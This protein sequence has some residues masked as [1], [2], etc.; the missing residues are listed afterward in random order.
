MKA[1]I[2][3]NKIIAGDELVFD[4]FMRFNYNHLFYYA[5]ALTHNR[6]VAEEIVSDAYFKMWKNR[7]ELAKISNINSWLTTIIYRDSISW[8]RKEQSNKSVSLNDIDDFKI[9]PFLSPD[10]QMISKEEIGNINK[11]IASLSS[12]NRHIFI[13]AKIE[14]L[15]YEDIAIMLNISL[16]T[17]YNN[18]SIA[19]DAI[20][21]CLD[22]KSD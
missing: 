20:S 8:L 17:I 11:A 21:R 16:K 15:P 4:Q 14:G 3:I 19:L 10:N 9:A 1:K 13:L 18:V 7:R 5:F 22:G 12:K 6:E 2:D